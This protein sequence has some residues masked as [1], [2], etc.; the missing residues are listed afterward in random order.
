MKIHRWKL[1]SPKS[2]YTKGIYLPYRKKYARRNSFQIKRDMDVKI[3]K[4]QTNKAVYGLTLSIASTV[5]ISFCD[6]KPLNLIHSRKCS[7]FGTTTY[8]GK[9]QC[10]PL[11]FGSSSCHCEVSGCASFDTNSNLLCQAC[12]IHCPHHRKNLIKLTLCTKGDKPHF[13]SSCLLL[14]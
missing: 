11:F 5:A 13:P 3:N 9:C 4:K 1:L 7:H 14:M 12:S 10:L 8:L 6:R 2:Q